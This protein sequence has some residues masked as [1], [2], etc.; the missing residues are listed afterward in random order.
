LAPWDRHGPR[1][2]LKTD[3]KLVRD[4]NFDSPRRSAADWVGAAIRSSCTWQ[5]FFG[6]GREADA[7][8]LK[9]FLAVVRESARLTRQRYPESRFQVILWDARNDQLVSAIESSLR[10]AGIAVYQLTSI[11][12]DSRENWRQH[13]LD[14]HDMHPNARSYELLADFVVDRMLQVRVDDDAQ[15]AVVTSETR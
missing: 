15:K 12:P 7:A 11:I 10:A 9:L 8:D 3:G 6:Y 1:Y 14:A 5:R 13:V 2:R 4:G